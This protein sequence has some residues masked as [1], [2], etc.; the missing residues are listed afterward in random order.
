[1][2]LAFSTSPQLISEGTTV[3]RIASLGIPV[4]GYHVVGVTMFQAMGHAGPAF[5]LSMSRQVFFFIPLVLILP[6]IFG[7]W[8]LWAACPLSDGLSFLVT[9]ALTE[10]QKRKIRQH[11]EELD[12]AARTM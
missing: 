5:I 11:C 1:L 7:L 2:I 4:V 9:L 10:P 8:G 3:L 6:P 12:L